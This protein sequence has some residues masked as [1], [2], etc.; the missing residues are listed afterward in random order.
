[1][2]TDW[3]R[4]WCWERLKAGGKEDD[5]GWAGWMTSQTQSTWVW[6]NSR[7]WWRTGKPGVLQFMGLQESDTT[8]R[9]NN[10]IVFWSSADYPN[11]DSFRWTE[12]G[13]SLFRT[14]AF[15]TMAI[16]M[17][18]SILP[19][20]PLLS[21]LPHNIEHSSLC[22]T[23]GPYWLSIL[24]IHAM[25]LKPSWI[26]CLCTCADLKLYLRKKNLTSTESTPIVTSNQL[27]KTKLPRVG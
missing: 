16:H 9:L 18:V 11:C 4:S 21:R 8:E 19:Q 6:A 5:K 15:R 7:T 26:T 10:K 14:M 3:T 23:V 22:Y 2:P 20:I 13:L 1:M 27:W 12:K 17:Y 25:T 24:N